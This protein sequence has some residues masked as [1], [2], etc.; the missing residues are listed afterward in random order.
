M[1]LPETENVMKTKHLCYGSC[2]S[3]LKIPFLTLKCKGY[4]TWCSPGLNGDPLWVYKYVYLTQ[5]GKPHSLH[6]ARLAPRRLFGF[7]RLKW[8]KEASFYRHLSSPALFLIWVYE[9]EREKTEKV[10]LLYAFHEAALT[11]V[12]TVIISQAGSWGTK[13]E[14]NVHKSALKI[15]NIQ[16]IKTIPIFLAT[17]K[18]YE[19]LIVRWAT[20]D[21]T[22]S[23]VESSYLLFRYLKWRWK[24]RNEGKDHYWV[25]PDKQ[26]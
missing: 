7:S 3:S 14:L 1:E 9:L 19:R 17:R 22:T 21:M 15:R 8:L 20:C 11:R 26:D 6:L 24:V 4:M 25:A 2:S 18:Y 23:F 10:R 13:A 12:N 5:S 16:R